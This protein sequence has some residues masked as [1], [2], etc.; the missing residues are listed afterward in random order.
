MRRRRTFIDLATHTIAVVGGLLCLGIVTAVL[1]W[2]ILRGAPHVDLHF[3]WEASRESGLAGGI[4]YQIAGTI[5]LMLTTL[6]VAVPLSIGLALA[7]TV[8]LPRGAARSALQGF[9]QLLNAMPSILFGI[10]GYL[11][12]FHYLGWGKSWLAGGLVLGWMILPT[13]TISLI[14]SMEAIPLKQIHAAAGLGMRRGQIIR[15]IYL[16]QSVRG[17]FTGSFLGLARAAGETAPI[18]FVATVFAGVSLPE[19]IRDSPVLALPYHIFV[20][21][22]D[23]LQ[24]GAIENLWATAFVLVA[25]VIG[26][27]LTVLPF[28]L[29]NSNRRDHA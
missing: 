23:S 16:P 1:G 12:F 19:G 24:A 2:I 4:R 5:I 6:A 8:Y 10:V 29:H 28:R 11:F 21:A 14:K 9:L 22:Q 17:L 13:V 20:L 15:S 27:S 18:L 3:F 25:L 7:A 26:L